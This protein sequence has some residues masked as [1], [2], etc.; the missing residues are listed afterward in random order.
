[1]PFER[2]SFT[3]GRQERPIVVRPYVATFPGDLESAMGSEVVT[4]SP[5]PL[6]DAEPL[7]GV[8]ATLVTAGFVD[9]SSS[10]TSR[11]FKPQA[12]MGPVVVVLELPRAK[13]GIRLLERRKPMLR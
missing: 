9:P 5:A 13:N 1:M 3:E 4:S 6:P 11:G 2:S 12:A 10:E 8:A 7:A